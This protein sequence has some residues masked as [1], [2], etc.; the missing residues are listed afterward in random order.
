MGDMHTV[1]VPYTVSTLDRASMSKVA[2][3]THHSVVSTGVLE[4]SVRPHLANLAHQRRVY[5]TPLPPTVC[6]TAPTAKQ[7][8]A[9]EVFTFGEGAAGQLGIGKPPY[10]RFLRRVPFPLNVDCIDVAAGDTTSYALTGAV[11][12]PHARATAAAA[13]VWVLTL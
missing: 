9:G 8:D 3:G 12:A 1:M 13:V 7:A 2:A 11:G 10:A 6:P 4:A 5:S